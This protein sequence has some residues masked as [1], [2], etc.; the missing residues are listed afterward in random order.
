MGGRERQAVDLAR[1]SIQRTAAPLGKV[2]RRWGD[3]FGRDGA[4]LPPAARRLS[5]GSV[6]IE[7]S[8]STRGW[9]AS[10]GGPWT[11]GGCEG[12]DALSMAGCARRSCPLGTLPD[13]RKLAG[14]LLVCGCGL[15]ATGLKARSWERRVRRQAT[16]S[17]AFRPR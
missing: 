11:S 16:S 10:D 8:A 15:A 14:V 3:G 13:A 17:G 6:A 12:E 7:G 5:V 9:G 1:P 2:A 4:A